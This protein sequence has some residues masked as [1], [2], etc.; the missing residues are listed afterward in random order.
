LRLH[1]G[2]ASALWILCIN[3]GQ[4]PRP[5]YWPEFCW[6]WRQASSRMLQLHFVTLAQLILSPSVGFISPSSLG[7]SRGS[8]GTCWD[9]GGDAGGVGQSGYGLAAPGGRLRPTQPAGVD[10]AVAPTGG[11][12]QR[13]RSPG[14]ALPRDTRG[15]AGLYANEN[16][17]QRLDRADYG[18]EADVSGG[19]EEI[20]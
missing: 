3:I 7:S 13:R 17:P 4:I 20:G 10:Q 6:A 12:A 8:S 19:G 5:H 2:C 16:R 9:A 1:T 15:S 14:F 11:A 18:W